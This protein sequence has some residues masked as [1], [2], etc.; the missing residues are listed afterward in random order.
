MVPLGSGGA[1]GPELASPCVLVVVEASSPCPPFEP[2]WELED[3]PDDDPE[4]ELELEELPPDELEPGDP[5]ADP[6]EF[7]PSPSP[8]P[9]DPE[10]PLLAPNGFPSSAVPGPE[11]PAHAEARPSATKPTPTV[12]TRIAPTG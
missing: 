1:D 11:P 8:D 9:V 7:P 4:E 6:L 10:D 12:H 3:D 2:G 5:E